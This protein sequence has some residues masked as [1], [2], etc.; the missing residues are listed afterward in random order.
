MPYA[1][2]FL[3]VFFFI[4]TSFECPPCLLTYRDKFFGLKKPVGLNLSDL[5]ID[6]SGV[7]SVPPTLFL[8]SDF[9]KN[10]DM[11]NHA[12]SPPPSL[13]FLCG[14]G[15]FSYKTLSFRA[16]SVTGWN[17]ASSYTPRNPMSATW[18]CT[19]LLRRPLICGDKARKSW[20]ESRTN[21]GQ[22]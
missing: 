14:Q 4:Q 11:P 18:T 6:V 1:D 19:W 16:A 10:R 12:F 20:G 2:M 15:L 3:P 9:I 17:S 5:L 21:F 7:L 8:C 13:L 22:N